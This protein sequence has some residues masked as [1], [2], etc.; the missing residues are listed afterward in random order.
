LIA[1]WGLL[2]VAIIKFYLRLVQVLAI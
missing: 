1:M 2:Y